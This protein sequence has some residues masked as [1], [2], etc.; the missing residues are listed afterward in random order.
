MGKEP[1]YDISIH[2]VVCRA[3]FLDALCTRWQTQPLVK[4]KNAR[5]LVPEHAAHAKNGDRG[6]QLLILGSTK[7][8]GANKILGG[9][10]VAVPFK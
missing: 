9:Q 3:E 6:E 7:T 4:P 1:G 5:C 8:G 2:D 10:V